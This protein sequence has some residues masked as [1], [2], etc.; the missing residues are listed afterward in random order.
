M[1]AQRKEPKM[2]KAST[3]KRGMEV[4]LLRPKRESSTFRLPE[5][6]TLGDLLREAGTGFGSANI[7]VDGRPIEDLVGLA[8]GMVVTI[9]PAPRTSPNDAWIETVG[10]FADDPT[11]EEGVAEGRAIREADRR[12]ALEE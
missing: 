12:A 6:A 4:S 11:F 8:S 2:G 3:A 5:G 10:M 7:L 1:R 9:L